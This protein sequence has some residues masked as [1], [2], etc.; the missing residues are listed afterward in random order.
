VASACS[1][2]S[3]QSPPE[4]ACGGL[5]QAVVSSEESIEGLPTLPT[6][7]GN[8]EVPI[9]ARPQQQPPPRDPTDENSGGPNP[10]SG[11]GPGDG[12]DPA[13]D[14]GEGDESGATGT[15]DVAESNAEK[16][17][18]KEEMGSASEAGEENSVGGVSEAG[19]EVADVLEPPPDQPSPPAKDGTTETTEE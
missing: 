17:N 13:E 19:E 7:G 9:D 12:D 16:E 10:A 1:E 8:P 3:D 11:E 18:Q 14:P 4:A 5:R 15:A 2:A 6:P